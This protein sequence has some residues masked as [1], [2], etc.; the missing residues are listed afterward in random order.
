VVPV[1][2]IQVI[3]YAVKTE[4]LFTSTEKLLIKKEKGKEKEKEVGGVW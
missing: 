1:R 3:I 2:V 4:F